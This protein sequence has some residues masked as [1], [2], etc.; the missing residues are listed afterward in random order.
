MPG[1]TGKR[2]AETLVDALG[3]S[4]GDGRDLGVVLVVGAAVAIHV[5]KLLG[6]GDAGIGVTAHD[7]LTGVRRILGRP[8]V[9]SVRIGLAVGL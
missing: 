1:G 2:S 7:G 9:D 4:A 6:L 8:G 5:L 3:L